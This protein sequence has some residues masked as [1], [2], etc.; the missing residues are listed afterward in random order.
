MVLK[1]LIAMQADFIL[2]GIIG[3]AAIL[4]S[5]KKGKDVQLVHKEMMKDIMDDDSMV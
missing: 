3:I 2:Y 1:P 4:F 5:F